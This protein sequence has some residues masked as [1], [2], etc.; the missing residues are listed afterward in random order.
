MWIRRR[1]MMWGMSMNAEP[2]RVY[3]DRI[4]AAQNVRCFYH[5]PQ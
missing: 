2:L 3:L 1:R 4:D 5:E